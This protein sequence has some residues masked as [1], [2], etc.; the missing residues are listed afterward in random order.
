[1]PRHVVFLDEV[2]KG[3]TGK[4]QRI[5]LA[6]SLE[7]KPLNEYDL[8][9]KSEYR[10]PST[11]LEQD[12][13]RIWSDIL[14]VK[15]GVTDNYFHL[16]GDSLKAEEI[17]SRISKLLNIKQLPL[18]IF[19]Q[20]PTIQAMAELL[21]Q[22]T[23]ET[24]VIIGMQD[25]GEKHPLYLIHAC[26]GE[27]LFFTDLVQRLDKDR[28]VYAL[29]APGLEGGSIGYSSLEELASIY[30]RSIRETQ[31]QGPYVIG[32]AGIGGLIGLEIARQLGDIS[33]SVAPLILFDTIPP[34]LAVKKSVRSLFESIGYYVSRVRF[35]W[36]NE[37]V[38][39]LIRA[40]FKIRYWKYAKQYDPRLMIR[41]HNIHIASKYAPKRYDGDV[42]LFMSDKRLGYVNDPSVRTAL[43]DGLLDGDTE[44]HVIHGVHT[45][46]LREPYVEKLAPI[47]KEYLRNVK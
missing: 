10:A 34:K 25:E 17:V 13:V 20:A 39:S 40:L 36:E 29:R 8:A 19:L 35:Y 6:E 18:V 24:P 28:P 31:T 7:V 30:V 11:K 41:V 44:V 27:V 46:I 26:A 42:L 21:Q 23:V 16:G 43:W 22:E 12:L 1:M 9:E 38:L 3:P 15:V 2:P 14:D 47:L 5:G 37:Q 33:E 45:E 32:G 4:L